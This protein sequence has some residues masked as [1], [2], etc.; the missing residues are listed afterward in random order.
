MYVVIVG[1]GKVGYYL[2]KELLK[3]QH[4]VLLLE[5]DKSRLEFLG[6]DLSDIVQLGDGCEIRQM[7]NAG[8]G[9]ADVVVA[10]TGDD[11][12]NLVICQM[13][14]RR[15][16]VKR[17]LAR[18]NDPA[19]EPLFHKLGIKE[20]LNS[21]RLIYN[22][23]EQSIETDEIVP[24]AA[25]PGK[26]EIAQVH[27]GPASAAAGKRITD[28]RLPEHSLIIA[29][30]RGGE[31]H[32]PTFDTRIAAEDTVVVLSHEDESEGLASIFGSN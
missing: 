1:G 27:I 17:V 6:K 28:L 10:V 31:A 29:V 18:V 30:L 19:N 12:D 8:F 5:K 32:I 21:T 9:R 15:F 3:E 26:K 7:E 2:S 24:L 13:A 23:L 25:L 11:E 14:Q 4:E 22:L 16:G 20:T